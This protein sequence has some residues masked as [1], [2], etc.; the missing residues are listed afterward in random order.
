MFQDTKASAVVFGDSNTWAFGPAWVDALT[1]SGW[2]ADQVL[3]SYRS[4][5][6]PRHW[7]PRSH[8]LHH[9]KYGV[10]IERAERG[11]P[12]VFDALSPATALVIIGLGGNMQ[13][14]TRD[15]AS[16]D[17]LLELVAQLAPAARIVWRG[18]PPSTAS[19]G[20]QVANR[21]T[22]IGR[23]RRNGMLKGRL[24]PLGFEVLGDRVK[25]S[26]R[27]IYLD[28]VAL[29][30]TGPAPGVRPLGAGRD[31]DFEA[32][33]AL[34]AGLRNDRFARNE[35]A[36]RGPW[37]SFVRA[38]DSLPSHVPRDT[39]ADLVDIVA[40]RGA[41][42]IPRT[43]PALPLRATVIDPKALLRQG[44]PR[45]RPIRDAVLPQGQAVL[46]Q[47]WTGRYGWVVDAS[48][49]QR[50][51]WTLRSNLEVEGPGRS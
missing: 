27:R 25:P 45:F 26:A 5:S 24:L 41:L 51:G 42:R 11:R 37:D 33:Q 19:K 18:T 30:A 2:P 47:M 15:D 32:E 34:V 35:V 20:G 49:G 38:R 16:A 44:G 43:D 6:T 9:S 7:L 40:R 8:R 17:A 48:T 4:G 29:H 22:R 13:P 3:L 21:A 23:H 46:L 14:G 28:V 10:L 36:T 1:A 50:L 31:V 12:A 39:A